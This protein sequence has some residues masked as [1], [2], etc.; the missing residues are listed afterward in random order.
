MNG[1]LLATYLLIGG[2][3]AD[4]SRSPQIDR[5]IGSTNILAVWRVC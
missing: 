3:I 1:G 2:V 5:V 4:L